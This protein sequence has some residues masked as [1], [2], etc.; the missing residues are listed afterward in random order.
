MDELT[1]APQRSS[2]TNLATYYSNIGALLGG[3]NTCLNPLLP[4]EPT[5]S[6]SKRETTIKLHHGFI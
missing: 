6:L 3:V 4:Q 2:P 1:W 5:G